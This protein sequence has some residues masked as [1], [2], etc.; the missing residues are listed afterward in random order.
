MTLAL[1]KIPGLVLPCNSGLKVPLLPLGRSCPLQTILL[2]DLVGCDSPLQVVMAIWH[3]FW[4]LTKFAPNIHNSQQRAVTT[5]P[6]SSES[7][8]CAK[9]PLLS[10]ESSHTW[11]EGR[12]L[13]TYHGL[14]FKGG[15]TLWTLQSVYYLPLYLLVEGPGRCICMYS[16][17]NF[18]WLSRHEKKT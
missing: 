10:A 17:N 9:L 13:R 12:L 15:E 4:N 7:K 8:K 11:L 16:I 18:L 5:A 2:S 6:G 3:P 14:F 1:K